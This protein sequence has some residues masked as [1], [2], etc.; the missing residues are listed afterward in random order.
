MFH[1]LDVE[2]DADERRADMVERAG[3]V[4]VDVEALWG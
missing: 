3:D 4:V 1:S 2:P